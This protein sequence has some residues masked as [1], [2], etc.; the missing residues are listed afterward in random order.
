M[1]ALA[2]IRWPSATAARFRLYMAWASMTP[3][4]ISSVSSGAQ[5]GQRSPSSTSSVDR[6][7]MAHWAA[8][9]GSSRVMS[10]STIP[11]AAIS[12]DAWARRW[13]S[14]PGSSVT[15]A[16]DGNTATRLPR[17]SVEPRPDSQ[18]PGLGRLD[19]SRAS[20]PAHTS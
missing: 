13:R 18:L 12:S 6:L 2:S 11:A 10:T 4:A 1:A 20:T 9:L 7:P 17:R 14:T 5:A 8:R 16:M 3:R 19:G 15:P